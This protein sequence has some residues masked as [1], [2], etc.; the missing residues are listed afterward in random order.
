MVGPSKIGSQKGEP[1]P[2]EYLRA[3]RIAREEVLACILR[4]VRLVIENH[5]AYTGQM[6]DKERLFHRRLTEEL[7]KRIELFLKNLAA[8][9]C[10]IDKNL[11][12]TVF[13]AKRN[14][15]YW[16]EVFRTGKS[17]EGVPVLT[18]PLDLSQ[19]VQEPGI[20]VAA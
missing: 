14:R 2:E 4:W 3:W 9:P 1:I 6:V 16:D 12:N 8:L 10:W 13:G 20:R 7:W 19:M 18:A 17:P 11:S 15:E 5:F